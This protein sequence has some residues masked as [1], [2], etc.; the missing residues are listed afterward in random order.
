MFLLPFP[1]FSTKHLELEK[2]A[3][4]KTSWI[5]RGGENE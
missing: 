2:H 3:K 4:T 5:C 1:Y